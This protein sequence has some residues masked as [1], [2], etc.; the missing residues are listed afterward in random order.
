[1]SRK[2]VYA[3]L[4]K[5]NDALCD[6]SKFSSVMFRNFGCYHS[7]RPDT[8]VVNLRMARLALRTRG[9]GHL[10]SAAHGQPIEPE[11]VGVLDM[12]EESRDGDT[13]G[14]AQPP[15]DR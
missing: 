1:M 11:R 8:R 10:G 15:S 12:A 2:R 5:N 6:Y 13:G 4:S 14:L 3:F 9:W 7:A